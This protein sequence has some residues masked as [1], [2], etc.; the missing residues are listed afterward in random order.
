MQEEAC[1][2]GIYKDCNGS[3]RAGKLSGSTGVL[4]LAVIVL[5]T[6][7]A[8]WAAH[9]GWLPQDDGTLAQ[10]AVRVLSGQL[11]NTDFVD[12]YTGGLSLLNALAFRIGGTNLLSLRYCAIIFF[13]PFVAA[14]FYIASRFA[15]KWAAA[16][17][18]LLCVAWSF[19][20][21]PSAMPS[22]YNLFF[23]GIGAAALLRY[24][25]V[26][27]S[28]WL[29][30]AGIAGGFS[31]LVKSTG[32]YYVAAVLLFMLFREQNVNGP[33]TVSP[34][35][36]PLYSGFVIAGL[37]AFLFVINSL[38]RS[39]FDERELY[40]FF[41]GPF[42]VACVIML[43]ERTLR[44][45]GSAVRFAT[46][47][48]LFAPFLVG[49]L[50]PLLAFL[51][52]YALSRSLG[53]LYQNVFG[54]IPGRTAALSLLRPVS[55]RHALFSVVLVTVLVIAA[56]WK[57]AASPVVTVGIP[58]ALAALLIDPRTGTWQHIWFSALLLTPVVVLSGALALSPRF[59]LE[60]STLRQQQIFL[61]LALAA[62][63]SLIQFPLSAPIYFCY[64][65]PMT[66]LALFA[67]VACIK[68]TQSA[69]RLVFA[70]VIVFYTL[71]AV[72]RL[73][74]SAIYAHWAFGAADKVTTLNLPRGGGL[75]VERPQEYEELVRVVQRL[76]KGGPIIA[77]PECPEVYFLTGLENATKD[78]NGA[79]L[80][81]LLQAGQDAR[82]HVIVINRLST[83]S[84]A[85]LTPEL[86]QELLA[87][88]PNEGRVGRYSLFWR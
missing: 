72:V 75:K 59:G 65:A 17:I 13:V 62:L 80:E 35:R 25:E 73:Q 88:F 18:T 86:H 83:F 67:V 42:V 36:S 10:S 28:R 9:R 78:D 2:P 79:S 53:Q 64:A 48:R 26:E 81:V 11:P 61:L 82:V 6:G 32:A 47:I 63:C 70:S 19:P 85:S 8:I 5:S 58:L 54:V 52:R 38:M 29:F 74:P 71:F 3:A 39:R 77:M 20:Q 66:A 87:R 40:A 69:S 45:C 43:R 57:R 68:R 56:T 22:W 4:F 44:P 50:L 33:T 84:G 7:Y 41:L 1:L 24:L 31:F 51:T 21:Y 16:A 14:T 60:L 46:L 23:A 34:R 37:V 76:S 49:L 12:N 15:S 55:P 30:L 27:R